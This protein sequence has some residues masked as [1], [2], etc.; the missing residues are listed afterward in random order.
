MNLDTNH[1]NCPVSL[2]WNLSLISKIRLNKTSFSIHKLGINNSWSDWSKLVG[3][4]FDLPPDKLILLAFGELHFPPMVACRTCRRYI[5]FEWCASRRGMRAKSKLWHTLFAWNSKG[6]KS[7]RKSQ[8]NWSLDRDHL[9][10]WDWL[11]RKL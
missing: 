6:Y 4:R 11:L 7:C 1:S 3:C 2:S 10:I 5:D 8:M 9:R